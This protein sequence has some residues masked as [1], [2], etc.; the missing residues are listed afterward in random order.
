MTD[1]EQDIVL[2]EVRDRVAVVTLNRPEKLNALSHGPGSMHERIGEALLRAE[3]D[4]EVGAVLVKGAGRAFCAGGDLS[5]GGGPRETPLDW[6]RFHERENVD[7]ARI[8]NLRKPTIGAIHGMCLGAGMVMA[9]HFD[10]LIAAESTRFGLIEMRSGNSAAAVLPYLIGFQ[11]TRYLAFTGE[12]ISAR[13]AADIGFVLEVV[14]DDE[15]DERTF[16]LARRVATM[17]AASL[18]FNRRLIN[19]ARDA[20]GWST[21]KH[22]AMGYD[23]MSD[24]MSVDAVGPSGRKLRAVYEQEGM[25]AY[26]AERDAS[27]PTP[28]LDW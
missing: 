7:N 24:F 22:L 15:L 18:L 25:A 20:M 4:D 8:T 19:G 9:A 23:S 2:Y 3:D 6:Y 27:F 11:W 1:P 10:L 14:P 13:R 12:L 28:W 26:K 21:H 16:E 5:R 17:P